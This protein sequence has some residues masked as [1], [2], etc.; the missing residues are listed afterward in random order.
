MSITEAS[1]SL[2]I[3]NFVES[4]ILLDSQVLLCAFHREQAWVRF[5][6]KG[7]SKFC[8]KE[9]EHHAGTRNQILMLL[10]KVAE[11]STEEEYN[12]NVEK[13]K[14]HPSYTGNRSIKAFIEDHWLPTHEVIGC[15]CKVNCAFNQLISVIGPFRKALCEAVEMVVRKCVSNKLKK[16]PELTIKPHGI[17]SP[18]FYCKA[19]QNLYVISFS[20]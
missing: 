11:S 10:R 18:S 2:M 17:L 9:K 5:F 15:I 16:M 6:N 1:L 8:D 13:L 19:C 3:Y 12:M 14:Q 7:S 4:L 20:I